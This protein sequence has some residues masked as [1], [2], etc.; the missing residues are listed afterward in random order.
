[1]V[2]AGFGTILPLT[3]RDGAKCPLLQALPNCRRDGEATSPAWRLVGTLFPCT[4]TARNPASPRAHQRF[5]PARGHRLRCVHRPATRCQALRASR[6]WTCNAMDGAAA[7]GRLDIL[8]R[9]RDTRSEGCTTQALFD[10]AARGHLD[11][12]KWLFQNY[13]DVCQLEHVRKT[14]MLLL[15]VSAEQLRITE[16]LRRRCHPRRLKRWTR[17]QP[18]QATSK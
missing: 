16:Y 18:Q 13:R 9:L 8:Q 5:S 14:T 12:V 1:M 7:K 6:T 11:V 3:R 4:D 2:S 10:A 17:K 15:A